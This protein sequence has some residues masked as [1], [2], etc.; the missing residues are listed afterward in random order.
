MNVYKKTNKHY[1]ISNDNKECRRNIPWETG[2]SITA[3]PSITLIVLFLCLFGSYRVPVGRAKAGRDVL[4]APAVQWYNQSI[5]QV[6]KRVWVDY[7][8]EKEWNISITCG[9]S[10]YK[11]SRATIPLCMQHIRHKVASR[12]GLLL[13]TQGRSVGFDFCFVFCFLDPYE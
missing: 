10:I 11:K 8:R 4:K 7:V 13:T 9:V 1:N 6:R 3:G 12:E 5:I 2:R